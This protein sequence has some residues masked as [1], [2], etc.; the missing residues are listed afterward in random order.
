MQYRSLGGN[1]PTVSVVGLGTWALGGDA[2][3]PAHDGESEDAIR[4]AIDAGVTLIDTAPAYGDGRAE[5]VVGRAIAGRRDE[6]VL[7][8]KVGIRRHGPHHVVDLSPQAVRREIDE[9]LRR[10]NVDT[11]DLYQI[12]WPDKK[13]PI[14]ETVGALAR[15]HEAGKFRFLG[16]SNFKPALLERARAV[17]PLTCLQLHYSLLN[18]SAES[19]TLPGCAKHGVGTMGYGSLAGGILTGKYRELP[20]FGPGDARG[21][22]YRFFCEPVWSAAG[23]LLE[24]LR[25]IAHERTRPVSQVAINWARRVPVAGG[26]AVAPARGGVTCALVGARTAAQ[27]REN[28]AAGEWELSGEELSRIERAWRAQI[29]PLR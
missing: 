17:F 8:T 19:H 26:G 16:V 24:T 23:R 12:H 29:A 6:V 3:G 11:I 28:A 13:T 22:F 14:E 5:E 2:W 18:R 20:H 27:A 9:S 15:L 10:L 7:A 25:A 4:A 21:E 1:G